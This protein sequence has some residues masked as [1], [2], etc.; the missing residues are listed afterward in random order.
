M[1]A[2]SSMPSARQIAAI[3]WSSSLIRTAQGR[4]DQV[5]EIVGCRAPGG[6]AVGTDL[7]EFGRI[8]TVQPKCRALELDGAAV[9]DDLGGRIIATA[10]SGGAP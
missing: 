3:S 7:L 6:P 4:A 1:A 10:T 8:D 2:P 5:R 9:D